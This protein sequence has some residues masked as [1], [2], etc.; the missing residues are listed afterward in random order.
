[1]ES[2]MGDVVVVDLASM[3]VASRY[4]TGTD[5]FG[6]GIRFTMR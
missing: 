5:P 1:M 6:G 2:G 3:A 4:K